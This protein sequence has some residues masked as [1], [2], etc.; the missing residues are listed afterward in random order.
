MTSG[1]G[2][3]VVRRTKSLLGADKEN[4]FS[5]KKEIFWDNRGA[6]RITLY[7]VILDA[8]RIGQSS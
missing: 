3:E 4:V 6:L 7:S 8:K 1:E 5:V 2:K